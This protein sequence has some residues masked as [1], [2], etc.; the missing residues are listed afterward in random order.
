MKKNVIFIL[1]MISV[2]C[3]M[4]IANANSKTI[5][6]SWKIINDTLK[7]NYIVGDKIELTVNLSNNDCALGALTGAFEFD[8]SFVKVQSLESDSDYT[9]FFVQ[10]VVDK[11][12]NSDHSNQILFG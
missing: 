5:N 6:M 12:N 10:G 7:P 9:N 8:S 3:F 4:S 2:V 1:V 11:M